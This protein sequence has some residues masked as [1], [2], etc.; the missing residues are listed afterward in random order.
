MAT[1]RIQLLGAPQIYVNGDGVAIERRK[2]VAILAYL[3]VSGRV[4]SRDSLAALFWPDSDQAHARMGLRR[5]LSSLNQSIGHDRIDANQDTIALV[6]S[7]GLSVDVVEFRK[8]CTQS[9]TATLEQAISLYAGDFMAG[10]SLTDCPDFDL[11]QSQQSEEVRVL[12]LRTLHRLASLQQAAGDQARL[13]E[14][15]R[16]WAEHDP[17]DERA[18]AHLISALAALGQRS[19]ALRQYETCA[20]LLEAELGVAPG[21]A[22]Q[23][24]VAAIQAGDLMPVSAEAA[25]PPAQLPASPASPGTAAS[26]GTAAE[27][28]MQRRRWPATNLP[29]QSTA[30]VGRTG[31]IASIKHLLL[32]TVECQLV[33]LVAPGGM[34]KTRLAIKAAEECVDAFQDGIHFVELEGVAAM[35]ELLTALASVL[36]IPLQSGRDLSR[37]LVEALQPAAMLLVL[38]NIEALAGNAAWLTTLTMAAPEVK[39]LATARERL[40]LQT[41][42]VFD[43]EGLRYPEL[44]PAGIGETVRMLANGWQEYSALR[45]F[46]ERARRSR[47]HLRI[48]DEVDALLRIARLTEGSPL[49]LELAAAWVRSMTPRQ[50]AADLERSLDLLRNQMHDR[51]SRH[52]SLRAVFEQSWAFLTADEQA[53]LAALAIF[54]G[55]FTREAVSDIVGAAQSQLTMLV[56][57]ALLRQN[58]NGR[59]ALHSQI[60]EF[61]AEKLASRSEAA[62]TAAARHRAFYVSFVAA[63]GDAMIQANHR[64]AIEAI[65]GEVDNIRAAWESALAANDLPA[66]YQ[67]VRPMFLFLERRSWIREGAHR[68]AGTI[69]VLEVAVAER[70]GGPRLDDGSELALALSR[71]YSA[72][73]YLSTILGEKAP[74]EQSLR[75]ALA[76]AQHTELDAEVGTALN[77]LANLALANSD[78]TLAE[79]HAVAGLAAFEEAAYPAGIASASDMLGLIAQH[80]GRF[81]EA[82]ALHRRSCAIHAAE[83]DTWRL[84]TS[85]LNL[86]LALQ[87]GGHYDE[88]RAIHEHALSIWEEAGDRIRMAW[89]LT[90]L[91]NCAHAAGDHAA[92]IACFERQLAL[93]QESGR[94]SGI[95]IGNYN[96]AMVLM[97]EERI[98]EAAQRLE[99]AASEFRAVG[100]RHGE[101]LSLAWQ[102]AA[103]VRSAAGPQVRALLDESIAIAH[104]LNRPSVTVGVLDAITEV[105]AAVGLFDQALA[106]AEHIIGHPA[107]DAFVRA[108]L[109]RRTVEWRSGVGPAPTVDAHEVAKLRLAEVCDTVAAM[110]VRFDGD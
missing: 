106:C 19:A 24:L 7:A 51:V 45:L 77:Y 76:L 96:L 48:D 41:E 60:R 8:L 83:D 55:S 29:R 17:L 27:T 47:L 32:D 79:R 4:L 62:M 46:A 88:A 58:A 100:H 20:Q 101:A 64:A 91:G 49:A 42:W 95:G 89:A 16:R 43:V 74:A 3:A 22:L 53:T 63:R 30:F 81:A 78:Y 98:A 86:G 10:F 15:A 105:F 36:Q 66:L 65:G 92:A 67:L 40:H 90:N 28:L 97:D 61:A 80:S 99:A 52:T 75:L 109:R 23:K 12:H 38:D 107:T 108:R 9:N 21:A 6:E 54:R 39:I 25:P 73:G 33:T 11:W 70:S 69:A 13:V 82:E 34:G 110:G 44:A 26:H 102:A 85:E 71:A 59:Y 68:M 2:S 56:D 18:H 94:R 1:L 50:I 57:R 5:A 84:A 87:S 35:D 31:E 72:H 14:T 104:S 37:T 93:D 103:T